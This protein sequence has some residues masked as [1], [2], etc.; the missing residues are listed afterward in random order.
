MVSNQ[1][2][3]LF[4]EKT[5][6]HL[7]EAPAPKFWKRCYFFCFFWFFCFFLVFLVFCFFG[8]F[9][10]CCFSLDLART[11]LPPTVG[12]LGGGGEHIY[13]YMH[14]L[15]IHIY[16]HMCIYI[17]ERGLWGLFGHNTLIHLI[18]LILQPSRPELN[19]LNE[20]IS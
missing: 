12:P 17:C 2:N 11:R 16:E 19:E 13:I 3:N 1:K 14:S 20:L 10:F 18:H 9:L 7:L 8:S 15:F 4:H 5:K 6:N